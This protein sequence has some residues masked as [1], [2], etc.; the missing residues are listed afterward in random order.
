MMQALNDEAS[1]REI[2]NDIK[3]RI[4]DHED[5]RL[6]VAEAW[7]D[8]IDSLDRTQKQQF[9]E[10]LQAIKTKKQQRKE[11]RREQQR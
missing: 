9:V 7:M 10:N 3:D 6:R 5:F 11:K 2:L 1:D 4:D 8:I